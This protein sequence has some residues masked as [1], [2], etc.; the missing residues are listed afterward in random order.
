MVLEQPAGGHD[1]TWLL[2]VDLGS[3]L[4]LRGPFVQGRPGS[5]FI[6][7]SWQKSGSGECA[8]ARCGPKS[9]ARGEPTIERPGGHDDGDRQ[10]RD[11]ALADPGQ[12]DERGRHGRPRRA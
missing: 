9:S 10:H 3:E 11:D 1:L 4:D 5:R 2:D 8:R 12:R 6:Y 7:L